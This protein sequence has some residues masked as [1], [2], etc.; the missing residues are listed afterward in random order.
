LRLR[1]EEW[2]RQAQSLVHS[3]EAR[4]AQEA[5]QKEELYVSKSRQRDQQ[6]QMKVDAARAEVQGQA[7]VLRRREV[8]ASAALRELESRLRQQLQ[9]KEE[10]AQAKVEQ[11][12]HEL[13]A[14][15]AAQAE[16]RHMAAQAQWE[17]ESEK[18]TRAAIEPFKALLARTEKERDEA[19]QSASEGSRHVQNLE[20]QLMEASTFLSGWRNGKN[21][22]AAA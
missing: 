20:K 6:W 15:F 18:R 22:A 4:L 12:E 17:T 1:E 8:E 19:R 7:E 5:Q 16:A 21:T 13:I 10:A 14:Q 11:R 9:Q 2:G 3:T